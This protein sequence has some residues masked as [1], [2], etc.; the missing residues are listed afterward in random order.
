MNNSISLSALFNESR[1]RVYLVWAALTG[2]GYIATHFYQKPTIN[3]VWLVI[4]VIG[5]YYMYKVMPL[6]VKQMKYIYLSWL[7]P[8][9]VGLV[10]SV[11][12][13]RTS[14]LPELVGY[15]GVFW[16]LVSA[17]G[18]FWNGLVDRP[19]QWYFVAAVACIV[20]AGLG[21]FYDSLL[22]SQYLIAAIITVWSMLMLVIFRSET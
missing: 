6:R 8:I 17:V 12:A 16:L 15:L 3:I 5:F 2:V 18:F 11:I 14:L 13:V 20:G 21:Y 4:S 22:I 1:S 7:I 19:G 9:A 10:F